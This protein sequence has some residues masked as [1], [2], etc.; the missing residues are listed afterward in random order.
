MGGSSW[1]CLGSPILLFSLPPDSSSSLHLLLLHLLWIYHQP[2]NCGRHCVSRPFSLDFPPPRI[3]FPFLSFGLFLEIH[4]N[5]LEC[6]P[7]DSPLPSPGT[8]PPLLPEQEGGLCCHLASLSSYVSSLRMGTPPL[9]SYPQDLSQWLPHSRGDKSSAFQDDLGQQE[10]KR[11]LLRFGAW[12]RVVTPV[13]PFQN[14]S[15]WPHAQPKPK[16]CPPTSV[17]GA[18][19]SFSASS[20]L[21]S[22]E[23]PLE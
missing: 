22:Q 19:S 4:Q 11:C 13:F 16:P 18:S 15:L 5:H 14:H 20:S 10:L 21:A 6:Q 3:T 9:L 8:S 17:S 23:S 7:G 2:R 1:G 12:T